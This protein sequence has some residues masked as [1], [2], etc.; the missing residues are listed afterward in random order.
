MRENFEPEREFVIGTENQ[1]TSPAFFSF[2]S[3]LPQKVQL[4]LTGGTREIIALFTA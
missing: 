1:D 4:H 2:L 3:S